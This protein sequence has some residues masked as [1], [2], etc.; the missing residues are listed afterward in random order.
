MYANIDTMKNIIDHKICI[1][2]DFIKDSQISKEIKRKMIKTIR[3]STEK[4]N[5]STEDK[6]DLLNELPKSLRHEIAMFMHKGAIKKFSF[7]LVR[8]YT[9][10]ANV[11]PFLQ[12]MQVNTNEMICNIGEIPHNLYFIV[13]GRILYIYGHDNIVYRVLKEGHYFGDIE[14]IK[15]INRK[16]GICAGSDTKLLYMTQRLLEKVQLEFPTV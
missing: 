4:V 5:F 2:D 10:I 9:F 13:S 3:L 6:E 12:M 1:A 15:K 11:F 7:F 16:Y 14:V 8:D